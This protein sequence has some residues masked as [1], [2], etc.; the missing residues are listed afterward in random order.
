MLQQQAETDKT[1]RAA[2]EGY[3]QVEKFTRRS[4]AGDMDIPYWVFQPLKTRG[5]KLHPALVWTHENIRGHL[6]EHYIPYIREA[7]ARGYVVIAPLASR[8]KGSFSGRQCPP[9]SRRRDS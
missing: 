6:Y 5:P 7:T 4:R 9:R 3:M 1:W 8:L 2:A